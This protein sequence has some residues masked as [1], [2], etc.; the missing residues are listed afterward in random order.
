MRL[1]NEIACPRV[2]IECTR[3]RTVS[4]ALQRRMVEAAKLDNRVSIDADHSPF[5]STPLELADHLVRVSDG[6]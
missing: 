5:L 3:D 6:L 4:I 2:Y 1:A